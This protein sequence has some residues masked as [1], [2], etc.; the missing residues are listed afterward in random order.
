MLDE[1]RWQF[2]VDRGGTFTDCI[3][4]HPSSGELS[5]VKVPSSDTAPL[6]GIRRL[7]GLA[8]DSPIPAC[9][10]RLGTTLGTN[11]LLERRGARSALLLTRGFGDLLALGDQTRPELFA[12]DIVRPLPLPERTL[13][14][15][16]RLDAAEN[17][18][19]RPNLTEVESQL[20]LLAHTGIDSVG[21][22]LLGDYRSGALEQP[23]AE[24]ARSLGFSHVVCGHEIAPGIGYLARASTVAIDA[25]LTPLLRSYL[26]RLAAELPGSRLLLMQSSGGLCEAARFR[27]VASVLSGPAG[28]AVALAA[29]AQQAGAARAVGFDMGGTS[30]DVSR[31]ENG[32]LSRVSEALVAGMR[33]AAPMIAVHTVAAGGGS[34]CRLDGERLSVGPD[35]VGAEPGPL[36]YG[37]VGAVELALSDVNLALGRLIPDRFPLPLVEQAPLAA[38]EALARRLQ[39]RGHHYSPW[40]V[41][42]GFLRVANAKMAQAIREVTI[43]RGFDLREHALVVFGG[44]GGQHACALARELGVREVLFHPQAGVLSAL[45]IGI[46]ELGWDGSHDAGALPLDEPSLQ[47]LTPAFTRLVEQG[48]AAL[49]R[50]GARAERLHESLALGLRYAGTET[51]LEVPVA[52]A[53]VAARCFEEQFRALFGY[54]HDGRPLEIAEARVNIASVTPALPPPPSA[55]AP[56]SQPAVSRSGRLFLDGAWLENVPVVLRESLEPGVSLT[57]PAI[58]AE[59]TGTIV[60]E[61]GFSL[62]AEAGGLLRVTPRAVPTPELAPRAS[63]AP[64]ASADPVLLEIYANRFMSIAEQ[65]GRT[66]QLTAMSVNIRERL[67]FSCAVF[68]A[69]GELIANAPHIPVHLG[70]MSESVKAVLEAHPTLEAGDVFVT[71]DPARGGSHLPDIT[72]VAPVHDADGQLRF[73]SAARGHHAD[74]GGSTPGSMPAFSRSL[75]EEGVVLCAVKAS[76]GGKFDQAL[77]RELFLAG[78]LPARRV[79]ENLADLEAQLAAARTGAQLLLE[80]AAERGMAEVEAYMSFVQDD[81]ASEVLRALSR[82]APGRHQFHDQ[83]DDG[84]PLVV[85]LEVSPQALCIDFSGTG[86]EHPGNLNAPRAVTLACVLYFLRVLVGKS[87][88][89]NGGCLRH[90]SVYVPE[91]CLLAP[92]PER[93]VAGGNVETSQ[94]VVD[95]L[96]GAAGCLAASQGSMNNLSFGDGSYGYY[97]TIA[98]GAGAG[99]SFPGASA[100]H[101]HMTN[102][103]ITDA[104]V[105]ERRFPVRIVEHAIRRGSGGD[106]HM[107]GGDGVR[108]TFEFLRPARV[109]LL[110]ERRRTEPFGLAGGLAG[111][112]GQNRL[113][114]D[115]LPG[116]AS[117]DAATGDRLTILTPGGGGFG[118]P[119]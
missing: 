13:E 22:T 81:A 38:L 73:F 108:R 111:A 32:R 35:S 16:G 59:L 86:A 25:Y 70:A 2:Y 46:A 80:L 116:A 15:P 64:P 92:G 100:V 93:A 66:L 87:I 91:R 42:E 78:P 62:G 88:P 61:P 40:D 20:T 30:T 34:V 119:P 77:L 11:A 31:V 43:G 27:G 102:T 33:I 99:P 49:L 44:A 115:E 104:E 37:R 69:R 21:I 107:P 56:A 19:E 55:H 54:V 75:S 94:R 1:P 6:I 95:L 36:C 83:L 106:G 71:N 74:V 117:F 5:V 17:V 58:V 65:M 90:V 60:L 118:K 4:K 47:A 10:V 28:G 41:A 8:P 67:D 82:L 48:R 97:E 39:Q 79:T 53:A 12:L 51:V 57:G 98:G 23:L 85:T 24:L 45:G 52:S 18:L 114:G 109:S 9:E 29:V 101:T 96:L 76:R 89:L 105:M 72:V 68:D 84:T 103:R 14:V 63:A 112:R 110:S 7:L 26:E 113:N 50:D 3:A